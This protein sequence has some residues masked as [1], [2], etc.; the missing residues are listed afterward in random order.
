MATNPNDTATA[1]LVV[2][3]CNDPIG[4]HALAVAADMG[5]RLPA[6]LHI[7]HAIE[8]SD[9]PPDSDAADW[10]EQCQRELSEQRE[11]V[12]LL[13]TDA[14]LSWTYELRRGDP[15]TELA[16]AAKEQDALLIVVGTRGEGLRTV[17]LRLVEPSVSHGVIHLQHQ[18]VLVVPAPKAGAAAHS[19]GTGTDAD[20]GHS[21]E[22]PN[23]DQT[24]ASNHGDRP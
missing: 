4:D 2:G 5:R 8:T 11:R 10:E 21:G 22:G 14:K 16:K 3:H 12:E 13:L 6:R 24:T 17:V 15:A 23:R 9:Y 7:V 20:S 1:T 19:P 18:P